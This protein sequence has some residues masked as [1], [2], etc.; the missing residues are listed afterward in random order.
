VR[1]PWRNAAQRDASWYAANARS[2]PQ[3]REKQ[4]MLHGQFAPR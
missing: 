4:L 3:K 1:Q 2:Q